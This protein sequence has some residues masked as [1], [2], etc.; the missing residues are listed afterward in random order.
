MKSRI[1]IWAEKEQRK[2]ENI[3][4][5]DILDT[6]L[7]EVTDTGN[8]HIGDYMD[9]GHGFSMRD[10]ESVFI[11][12]GEDL[13]GISFSRTDTS[14]SEEILDF[15]GAGEIGPMSLSID[16]DVGTVRNEQERLAKEMPLL[17]QNDIIGMAVKAARK[18]F[19]EKQEKHQERVKETT[20][21]LHWLEGSKGASWS[22]LAGFYRHRQALKWVTP[23]VDEKGKERRKLNASF[24]LEPTG[25]VYDYEPV[26]NDEGTQIDLRSS[27]F[28]QEAE[29]YCFWE[30]KRIQEEGTYVRCFKNNGKKVYG[31]EEKARL[32]WA[33]VDRET[34]TK[35]I[36]A[37]V[38]KANRLQLEKHLGKGA[39]FWR[40]LLE[41]R[42]ECS[43]SGDWSRVYLTKSQVDTILEEARKR[44]KALK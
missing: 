38:S 42:Q 26:I 13:E 22:V 40:R 16:I 2:V 30:R 41:S 29:S 33:K 1:N 24:N 25:F 5:Q 6:Y 11:G 18:K 36:L 19:L 31:E 7:Q 12:N 35:D 37:W 20:K 44:W 23:Y 8:V 15:F 4:K 10:T 27:R 28:D 34:L 21:L 14:L 32:M 17:P 43:K 3:R 9:S 39:D